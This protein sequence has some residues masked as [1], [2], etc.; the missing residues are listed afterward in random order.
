MENSGTYVAVKYNQY[1]VFKLLEVANKFKVPNVLKLDDV[2][3]TLIYSSKGD[4]SVEV[5]PSI[6]Y[7]AIP[8]QLEIWKSSNGSSCLVLVL[9]SDAM[10][11]RHKE[12][13]AKHD[14][15]YDYNEYKPHVTISYNTE[16]WNELEEMNKYII[17]NRVYFMLLTTNEYAEELDIGWK[18]NK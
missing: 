13:M 5:Y 16:D 7:I 1:G 9:N 18:D 3:T 12:L 6:N 11:N 15:V 10:V 4:N 2:H 8:K 14:F 17:E